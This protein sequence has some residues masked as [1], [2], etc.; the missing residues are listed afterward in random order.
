MIRIL[1]KTETT[2]ARQNKSARPMITA[3]T[4]IDAANETACSPEMP[5]TVNSFF[6]KRIRRTVT[7]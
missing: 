7:P 2:A 4:G 1:A 3:G 6:P 5:R